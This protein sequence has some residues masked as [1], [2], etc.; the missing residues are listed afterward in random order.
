MSVPSTPTLDAGGVIVPTPTVDVGGTT[1]ADS[2]V[3][4]WV[5]GGAAVIGVGILGFAYYKKH[6]RG[7]R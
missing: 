4:M 5:I 6:H 1:V 2:T 3:A 7:R